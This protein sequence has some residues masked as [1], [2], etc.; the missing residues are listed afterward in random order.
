MWTS[1]SQFPLSDFVLDV[2]WLDFKWSMQ[3]SKWKHRHNRTLLFHLDFFSHLT[4]YSR[5][6][7]ICS[8]TGQ[9]ARRCLS[10]W[11]VLQ[12]AG[13]KPSSCVRL[14][15]HSFC[16]LPLIRAQMGSV[17]YSVPEAFMRWSICF[18]KSD[19]KTIK[20]NL[21]PGYLLLSVGINITKL[22]VHCFDSGF[23]KLSPI[24][25]MV[26]AESNISF[27]EP[28]KIQQLLCVF[29]SDIFLW[30]IVIVLFLP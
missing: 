2:V 18:W 3:W 5:S 4:R 8:E 7:Q 27:S 10:H 12:K 6:Q 1:D 11:I 13:I 15:S 16:T 28:E 22:M 30:S 29:C 24:Y 19:F 23:A 25:L 26:S 21:Q 9:T 14:W 17:L 20:S